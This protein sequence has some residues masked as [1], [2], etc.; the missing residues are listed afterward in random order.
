M[1]VEFFIYG[2]VLSGTLRVY[3]NT[4][5]RGSF[6]QLPLWMQSQ[7]VSILVSLYGLSIFIFIALAFIVDGFTG[8]I[9]IASLVIGSIIGLIVLPPVLGNLLFIAYPLIAL[10]IFFL[11]LNS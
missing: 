4:G 7:W 5:G 3:Q 11:V 2:I 8:F 6:S 1:W 9:N 10:F